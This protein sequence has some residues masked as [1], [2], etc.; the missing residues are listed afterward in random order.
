VL[1]LAPYDIALVVIS[2]NSSLRARTLQK[3]QEAMDM[4]K[5]LLLLEAPEV[6]KWLSI[7]SFK[8][9]NNDFVDSLR[10]L[11]GL[12]EYLENLLAL[13]NNAVELELRGVAW[14]VYL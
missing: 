5:N 6:V 1:D 7:A 4:S 13:A 2:T 9:K 3:L 10:V 8:F 14:K 12:V 11:E